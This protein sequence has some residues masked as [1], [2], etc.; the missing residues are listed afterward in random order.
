MIPFKGND[1][2]RNGNQKLKTFNYRTWIEFRRQLKN[3]KLK[4]PGSI[5]YRPVAAITAFIWIVSNF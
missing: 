4:I 1:Q 3:A 5:V 2:N